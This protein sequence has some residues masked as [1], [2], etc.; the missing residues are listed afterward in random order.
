[1]S[2]FV[3]VHGS[4]HGAWCWTKVVPLLE[5][6]GH[7]VLALDLPGHG[8]DHTPLAEISLD[9]YASRI[10]EAVA[11]CTGPIALVGH[12]MGGGAITQAS[13][14]CADALALL[15]Y[16][17]AFVP[18]EGTSIADQAM[19]DP[20]SLLTKHVRIDA[21]AGIAAL[22][23]GLIDECF[24]ADCSPEDV[25]FARARL[26]DD[27]LLPLTTALQ[28]S[29]EL[30]GSVPRVYVECLRDRTLTPGHQRQ[31]R[32]SGAWEHV[33]RLDTSHSPFFSAPE[34]LAEVLLASLAHGR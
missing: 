5:A 15:V 20:D 28:V 29:P 32:G 25:A 6:A 30:S 4:W 17:A 33:H 9:A 1:M 10:C 22:D 3:L 24:Y 23:D 21:E 31:I 8:D 34:E 16:L 26:R 13:E 2:S 11:S 12:S 27:P 19:S 14:Y 7:D 18:P